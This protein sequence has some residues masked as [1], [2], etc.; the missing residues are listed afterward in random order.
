MYKLH[1]LAQGAANHAGRRV[2]QWKNRSRVV[3]RT[4]ARRDAGE[5]LRAAAWPA[6]LLVGQL[7]DDGSKDPRIGTT[8]WFPADEVL[9][10][11]E[12]ADV[13]AALKAY[14]AR[15]KSLDSRIHKKQRWRFWL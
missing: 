12:Y 10:L 6:N 8:F 3:K 7:A 2:I 11:T 14:A 9:M 15:D 1:F 4:C 13:Q 5:C